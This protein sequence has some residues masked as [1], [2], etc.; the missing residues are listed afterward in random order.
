MHK[1]LTIILSVF[2][3]ISV[4]GQDAEILSRG[5]KVYVI[6][7]SKGRTKVVAGTLEV[8]S[9]YNGLVALYYEKKW[10]IIDTTGK[11][12]LPAKYD[13]ISFFSM[14]TNEVKTGQKFG[15][16]DKK[17]REIVSPKYDKLQHFSDGLIKVM[18]K[19]KWGIVD[20]N[21]NEV[22]AAKYDNIEF[23]SK[24]VSKVVLKGKYGFA[25]MKGNEIVQPKYETV[26]SLSDGMAVFYMNYKYGCIDSLAREVI[27]AKYDNIDHFSE[28][29]A[30]AKLNDKWGF[31]NKK[32]EE[33][34]PIKYQLKEY[35][36]KPTAFTKGKS[37][38]INA[39]N[40]P[41]GKG[42][43]AKDETGKF[44]ELCKEF[45]LIDVF[46]KEERFAVLDYE[47]SFE[48][49]PT[50]SIYRN[51]TYRRVAGNGK[52]GI[53][54]AKYNFI[55]PPVC[56]TIFAIKGY[57]PIA[58]S[59]DFKTKSYN[60]IDL[61]NGKPY[62]WTKGQKEVNYAFKNRQIVKYDHKVPNSYGIDYGL[63]TPDQE[64]LLY[65]VFDFL[66]VEGE[67]IKANLLPAYGN[68]VD[69]TI[70]IE[71]LYQHQ[72]KFASPIKCS[73]CEGDGKVLDLDAMSAARRSN[74][75]ADKT[76]TT[77]RSETT[78]NRVWNSRTNSYEDMQG[79]RTITTTTTT[80]GK[81]TNNSPV[82]DRYMICGY[83]AGKGNFTGLLWDINQLMYKLY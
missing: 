13:G 43:Y 60:Y 47:L 8:D 66:Q 17:G 20:Y 42:S 77:T 64:I 74:R 72:V 22:V 73:K 29:L 40:I 7:D 16:V 76:E 6:T 69:V 31:V 4:Y 27:P 3:S 81:T 54:D 70:H 19:N 51:P 26:F 62:D 52:M 18:L 39:T 53:V 11:H 67:Y 28:G 33:V 32:G 57:L 44:A 12:F 82:D 83:C 45:L 48:A 41:D 55:V 49:S 78:W 50:Y 65:P 71:E 30:A 15:L 5:E 80:P 34:I 58:I 68:K 14:E 56:D 61:T 9:F 36:Q 46:G 25:D 10:R 75:T 24:Q 2:I 1:L 38:I 59:H 37:V 63:K 21:G 79:T 35:S 23:F